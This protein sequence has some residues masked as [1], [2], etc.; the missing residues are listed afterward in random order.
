MRKNQSDLEEDEGE[1]S[2]HTDTKS[3]ARSK[4]KAEL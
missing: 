3:A 4:N 1:E 2:A